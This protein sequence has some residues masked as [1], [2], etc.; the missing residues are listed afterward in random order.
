MCTD[1]VYIG[2]C[3]LFLAHRYTVGVQDNCEK[4]TRDFKGMY[5]LAFINDVRNYGTYFDY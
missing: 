3:S 4:G 1:A 5:E 2:G